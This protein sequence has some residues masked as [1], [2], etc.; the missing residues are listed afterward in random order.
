MIHDPRLLDRL[1]ALSPD[2]WQGTVYR[3]M[4]GGYPPDRA[5]THGARW[6]PPG[7]AAIYTSLDELTVIAEVSHRLSL[8][9][10]CPRT[11][12]AFYTINAVRTRLLNLTD[13]GLLAELGLTRSELESYDF[14]PCQRVG[15]AAAWL[16][17][18]GIL[19]PS[20]RAPGVNLV[21][22]RDNED[23]G[24]KFEVVGRRPVDV[25][26]LWRPKKHEPT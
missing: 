11:D 24:A 10:V 15:G 9:P 2:Q 22:F 12:V 21:L 6:N 26:T 7:V 1:E 5:N 23:D 17:A 25:H 18:D 19:V 16:E 13:Q 20:A 3:V 8:E 14:G 4:L